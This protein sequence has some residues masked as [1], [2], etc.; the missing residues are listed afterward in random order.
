[1]HTGGSLQSSGTKMSKMFRGCGQL[2]QILLQILPAITAVMRLLIGSAL[3][4]LTSELPGLAAPGSV[5]PAYSA[6]LTNSFLRPIASLFQS[7]KQPQPKQ[8]EIS[9]AG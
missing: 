1:M 4:V 6:L 5:L 2:M 3:T 7:R 8:A 9:P